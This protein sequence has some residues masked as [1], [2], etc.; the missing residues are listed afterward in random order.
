M[1]PMQEQFNKLKIKYANAILLFRLGDFY[2]AFND[3]AVTISKVLGITL[4][5]RGKDETRV[6]MAGIPYHALPNYLPK[7]VEAGLKVAIADQM[8]EASPGKLVDRQVSKIIT[9]GTVID[10]NSLDGS[11]NNYIAAI[12]SEERNGAQVFYLAYADLT[13][14]EF[15]VFNTDN[16]LIL[17]N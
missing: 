6:P 10:E 5:G 1:T 16:A 9:P 4:T 2:E 3:D 15:K 17:R 12:Y 14:A 7:L 13:T 11:K 8:E